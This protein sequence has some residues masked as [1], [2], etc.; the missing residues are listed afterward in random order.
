MRTARRATLAASL[1]AWLAT[2]CI[3]LWRGDYYAG[4]SSGD[5]EA[6]VP[7][8]P[9]TYATLNK[10]PTPGCSVPASRPCW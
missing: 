8:N 9:I 5:L 1:A 3:G 2:G 6:C 4:L 10:L 7:F